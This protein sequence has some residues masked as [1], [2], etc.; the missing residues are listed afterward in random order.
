GVIERHGRL[1]VGEIASPRGPAARGTTG[2][3]AVAPFNHPRPRL[4]VANATRRKRR[5]HG[6]RRRA[7]ARE[8][9]AAGRMRVRHARIDSPG[10]ATQDEIRPGRWLRSTTSLSPTR[11][12]EEIA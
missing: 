5:G 7:A 3:R 2:C 11:S 10:S 8:P 6:P 9:P 1:L 4:A 12:P